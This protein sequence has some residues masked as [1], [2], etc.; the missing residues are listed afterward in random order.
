MMNDVVS[1]SL[2][3]YPIHTLGFISF[4]VPTSDNNG[5]VAH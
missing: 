2:M 5:L 1:G 3:K 4:L